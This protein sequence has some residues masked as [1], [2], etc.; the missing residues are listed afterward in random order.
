MIR[1]K[2]KKKVGQLTRIYS[3]K[4]DRNAMKIYRASLEFEGPRHVRAA[5]PSGP[6][7]LSVHPMLCWHHGHIIASP[8]MK[9]I[10]IS[11]E[12]WTYI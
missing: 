8:L 2:R 12:T 7:V 1:S 10:Q 5:N 6:P 3:R 4:N 11:T 9:V